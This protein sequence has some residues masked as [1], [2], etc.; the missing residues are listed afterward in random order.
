MPRRADHQAEVRSRHGELE[1]V[2]VFAQIDRA[3]EPERVDQLGEELLGLFAY[4][5]CAHV[6][7]LSLDGLHRLA[8]LLRL[9]LLARRDVPWHRDLPKRRR[10]CRRW[11]ASALSDL[12]SGPH[13]DHV[14]SPLAAAAF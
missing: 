1:I 14:A 6:G 11:S 7:V 2:A 12:V 8:P 5:L 3:V 9:A 13:A 4:L 10:Y